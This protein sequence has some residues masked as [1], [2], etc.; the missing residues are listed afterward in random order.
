MKEDSAIFDKVSAASKLNE[1]ADLK[2]SMWCW[3]GWW[4]IKAQSHFQFLPPPP[5]GF[6]GGAWSE[7][8]VK[9][10]STTLLQ[11]QG[12]G[13]LGILEFH[14]QKQMHY[15]HCACAVLSDLIRI[16]KQLHN[17]NHIWVKHCS[18]LISTQKSMTHFLR[19]AKSAIK[20][21]I[22]QIRVKMWPWISGSGHDALFCW[23]LATIG[24]YWTFETLNLPRHIT[25]IWLLT[26]SVA[27]TAKDV[28]KS[29][30]HCNRNF[31][32]LSV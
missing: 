30:S 32:K 12:K 13:S 24:N 3:V 23:A 6:G 21:H 26:L 31:Q 28:I 17:C 27:V 15:Q 5:D 25:F 14:T 9:C 16:S 10:F 22:Q 4:V 29:L 2:G 1:S 18:N 7:K 20:T 19:P 8:F 11:D